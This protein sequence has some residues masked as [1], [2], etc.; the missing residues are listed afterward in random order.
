MDPCSR[1]ALGVALETWESRELKAGSCLLQIIS[2]P[3]RTMGLKGRNREDLFRRRNAPVFAVRSPWMLG[4]GG[5]PPFSS[6]PH[7]NNKVRPVHVIFRAL[8]KGLTHSQI[9]GT[10]VFGAFDSFCGVQGRNTSHLH[11]L[12]NHQHCPTA[13]GLPFAPLSPASHRGIKRVGHR[14]PKPESA[15]RSA[16]C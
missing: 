2:I 14:V 9:T 10:P 1:R 8:N 15:A 16:G 11:L 5:T 13:G 6:Q 12:K 7:E 3:R 4:I